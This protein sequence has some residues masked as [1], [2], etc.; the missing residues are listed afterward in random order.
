MRD[1]TLEDVAKCASKK[2]KHCRGAGSLWIWVF[3]D[4]DHQERIRVPCK[5]SERGFWR[6]NADKVIAQADG[7]YSWKDDPPTGAAA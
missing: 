5:C 4:P 7:H 6:Q 1:V 2:C 3:T